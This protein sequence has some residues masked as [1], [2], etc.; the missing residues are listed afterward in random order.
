MRSMILASCMVKQ[1]SEKKRKKET[2][3]LW[4]HEKSCGKLITTS[5]ADDSLSQEACPWGH[6]CSVVFILRTGE[7]DATLNQSTKL[8]ICWHKWYGTGRRGE[9]MQ[10]EP[11]H[12]LH[13]EAYVLCMRV[14]VSSL[15]CVW[16]LACLKFMHTWHGMLLHSNKQ[17]SAIYCS[18]SPL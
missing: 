3:V 18:S 2:Y 9:G 14:H 6:A 4:L 5:K 13:G 8:Y 16:Y 10:Q 17:E 1:T 12:Y 7:P 11:G 15:S